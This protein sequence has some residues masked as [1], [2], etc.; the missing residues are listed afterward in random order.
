MRG[1]GGERR[2]RAEGCALCAARPGRWSDAEIPV[3]SARGGGG[4]RRWRWRSAGQRRQTPSPP[5]A[6][7]APAAAPRSLGTRCGTPGPAGPTVTE[8]LAVEGGTPRA[9]DAAP[10]AAMGRGEKGTSLAESTQPVK[11]ELGVLSSCV[12]RHSQIMCLQVP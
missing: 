5:G 7:R 12:S 11:L 10:A 6:V 1:A 4:R 3:G 9:G 8:G 2:G